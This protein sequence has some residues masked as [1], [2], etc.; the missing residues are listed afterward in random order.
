MK[1]DYQFIKEILITMEEYE[2]H[3]IG[4]YDLWKKIGVMDEKHLFNS[5]MTDKFL[6]HIKVLDDQMFIECS[7]ENY[8]ILPACG[9]NL[10]T[11]NASFRI[12]AQ[13]YEFLDILKNDTIFNKIKNFALLNGFEIGKQ[14]LISFVTGRLNG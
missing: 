6:G 8:G 4:A 9:H 11:T 12:T 1:L 13:G 3:E 2:S 7:D 10:G 14:L 5:K